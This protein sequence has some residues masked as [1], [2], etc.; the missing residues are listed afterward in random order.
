MP[1]LALRQP[2][3]WLI[4]KKLRAR[5][6]TNSSLTFCVYEFNGIKFY[7][8]VFMWA[9][10]KTVNNVAKKCYLHQKSKRVEFKAS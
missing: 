10:V 4:H 6:A 7:L 9:T 1:L 2:I 8:E 5:C 3:S